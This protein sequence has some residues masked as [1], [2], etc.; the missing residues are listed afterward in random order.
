MKKA[1]GI[2]LLILCLALMLSSVRFA[3]IAEEG[4]NFDFSLSKTALASGD[5]FSVNLTSDEMT[6]SSI[7]CGILFDNDKLSCVSIVGSDPES[8]DEIGINKTE[9][10]ST[11]VEACF[12][13]SVNEAN[14]SGSIGAVF[15]NENDVSYSAG[16]VF[17]ATF[18]AKSAGEAEITL[19]EDTDGADGYRSDNAKSMQVLVYDANAADDANVYFNT[20]K[21][22][23]AVGERVSVTLG[24][25]EMTV[26]AFSAG[27]SFDNEKLRCVSIVGSDPDY[28]NDIGLNM[29]E[30]KNPWKDALIAATV[31]E[32]NASGNIGML[33]Y[34][35]EDET[36]VE[37]VIFTATFEA[38]AEGEALISL[39]EDSDGADGYRSDCIAIESVNIGGKKL[40]VRST[41]DSIGYSVSG[42][43]VTVKCDAACKAGYLKDGAYIA[44]DAV[45]GADGYSFT[46]PEGADELLLTLKGDSNLDGRVTAADIARINAHKLGKTVIGADELFAG[47][48]N[49]DGLI[50]DDDIAAIKDSVLRITPLGW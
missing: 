36:Y 18:L 46:A 31:E 39:F 4:T 2:L 19:Y 26:A 13:P 10:K 12:V 21:N 49:G 32:A 37:G 33:V 16:E 7:V 15:V 50:T 41:A 47:D 6:V 38:I 44:I 29:K 35:L 27:I 8:P 17:T 20:D 11:R 30:G 5:T 25:K 9:G 43:V 23:L 28:P 22:E 14:E 24:S 40:A 45:N 48:V 42:R 1:N 34:S 3:V